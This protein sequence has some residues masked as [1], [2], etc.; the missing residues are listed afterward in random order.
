MLTYDESF[1]G[2]VDQP[3]LP[4]DFGTSVEDQINAKPISNVNGTGG[5]NWNDALKSV[6]NMFDSGLDAY[7]SVQT[8]IGQAQIKQSQTQA[9][10]STTRQTLAPAATAPMVM[11]LNQTQMLW[12]AGG[13]AAVLVVSMISRRA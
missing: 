8:S 4:I 6:V 7:N 3:T 11:G 1:G 5:F 10:V 13:L 12:I 9:Q 2:N